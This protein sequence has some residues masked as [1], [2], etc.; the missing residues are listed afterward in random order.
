MTYLSGFCGQL[1]AHEG[2]SPVWPRS[3]KPMKVCTIPSCE[4]ECHDKLDKLFESTDTKRE[5]LQNPKWEPEHHAFIMPDFREKFLTVEAGD[6]DGVGIDQGS[7]AGTLTIEGDTRRTKL[8]ESVLPGLIPGAIRKSFAPTASGRAARGQMEVWVKD[9]C[10]EW[11][12]NAVRDILCTSE[13]VSE[14]IERI[15]K[16]PAV[17]RGSIDSVFYRWREIGFAILADRPFRFLFYT[18]RG[19]E[20][21]LDGCV[22][23]HKANKR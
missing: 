9:V 12:L 20:I 5:Y 8:M 19:I 2:M 21:G 3:G 18:P 10:D 7:M 23:E 16:R 4:C 15:F 11:T 14:E 22:A 17:P 1:G 13:Y 6:L